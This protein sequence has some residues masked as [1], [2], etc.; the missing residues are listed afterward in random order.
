M[1]DQLTPDGPQKA[2]GGRESASR[3]VDGERDLQGPA[4]PAEAHTAARPLTRTQR[5][6]LL[7]HAN[8]VSEELIARWVGAT[9]DR[10]ASIL[11]AA[12]QALGADNRQQAV[13]TAMERGL[14]GPDDIRRP[15]RLATTGGTDA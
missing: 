6:A 7:L 1:T 13:A 15:A 3:G 2:T 14:F 12:C 4:G 9:P 10:I 8:E 5:A 11:T